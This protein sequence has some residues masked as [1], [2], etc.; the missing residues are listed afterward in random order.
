MGEGEKE[1]GEEEEEELEPNEEPIV[2]MFWFFQALLF[3]I[4]I[5]GFAG[6]EKGWQ[7]FKG[8]VEGWEYNFNEVCEDGS[9]HN[10]FW[11]KR[12]L[13]D[14]VFENWVQCRWNTLRAGAF[15][16]DSILAQIDEWAS[17]LD[18]SQERNFDRWPILGSY[19]WPNQFLGETYEEEIEFMKDWISDRLLWM[20]E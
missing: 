9:F 7:R 12:M 15:S 3:V 19:V 16:N 2:K 8:E 6:K 14:P 10:P 18:E 17:F 11:W 1:A 13:T 4:Y 20:D 5:I